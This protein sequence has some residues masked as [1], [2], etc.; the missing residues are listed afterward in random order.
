MAILRTCLV[1]DDDPDLLE[2][3][4]MNLRHEGILVHTASNGIDAEETARLLHPDLVVLDVMMPGHD[5]YDVLR[6]LKGS[7][8]TRDIPVVLLT[9][10]AADDEVWAGWAAGADYYMTKPFNVDEL[11]YYV[12]LIFGEG[13]GDAAG[14]DLAQTGASPAGSAWAAATVEL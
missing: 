5:G 6:T 9:A 3:V 4:V 11:I 7:E 14:G 1:V 13:A 2:V 12:H 8:L 10:K